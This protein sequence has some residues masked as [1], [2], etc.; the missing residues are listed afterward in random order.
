MRD[1]RTRVTSARTW[2]RG[3]PSTA[4]KRGQRSALLGAV[5]LAASTATVLATAN[6]PPHITSLTVT[7]SVAN[8]GQTVTLRGTFTD[9][10]TGDLHSIRIGWGDDTVTG[11]KQ[12]V[13]L[14]AGQLSFQV[15]HTYTDD[16]APTTIKVSVLDRQTPP[17]T[18][19]N[20]TGGSLG[21]FGSVPI[22]VRNVPPGFVDSSIV[23][24]ATVSGVVVEGDFVDPGRDSIQV[25]GTINP[26]NP[27]AAAPMTCS[28]GKGERH[29]RCEYTQAPNALAQTY[30][31]GL[32]VVDDDGGFDTHTMSV[33]FPGI[34]RP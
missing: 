33:R 7:P 29:F 2:A 18:N 19:D 31:I 20:T 21:V 3:I 32:R 12:Q 6:T 30:P 10:D 13:Q 25:F 11:V 9:P 24:T 27:F 1:F 5:L 8:E 15:T 16:L 22:Q 14:P 23:G 28:H 26:Q 34:T 17:G 4:R